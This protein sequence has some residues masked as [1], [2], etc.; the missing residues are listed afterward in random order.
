ML[1]KQM[2]T[3]YVHPS[4]GIW[5]LD[6]LRRLSIIGFLVVMLQPPP[7]EAQSVL[8][9]PRV[10]SGPDSFTGIAVSNP[11]AVDASVTFSAI[12]PDGTNLTGSG[13]QNPT[14]VKIPAGG[15]YARQFSEIFNFNGSFNGWVQ[16]TSTASGLDGFFFNS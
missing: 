11:A 1:Y 3:H 14:T 5:R 9:F 7:A 13:L 6:W 2:T 15:Q 12:Q 8:S 10:I 4:G 16:A